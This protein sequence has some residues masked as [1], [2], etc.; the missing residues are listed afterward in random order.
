MEAA[1]LLILLTIALENSSRRQEQALQT[2]G[3]KRVDIFAWK[4]FCLAR[5]C[6][7]KL[8]VLFS[9]RRTPGR[10][11]AAFNFSQCRGRTAIW[12]QWISGG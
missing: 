8:S 10:A 11:C 6:P 12:R 4:P 9:E 5:L 1:L 7:C 3:Q 2:P